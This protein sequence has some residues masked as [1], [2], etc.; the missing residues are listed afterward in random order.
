MQTHL[1]FQ[2]ALGHPKLE[3]KYLLMN[4][5]CFSHSLY[6]SHNTCIF[7][8][9]VTVS[10]HLVSFHP[11][12]IHFPGLYTVIRHSCKLFPACRQVCVRFVTDCLLTSSNTHSPTS[13]SDCPILEILCYS[14]GAFSYPQY[15][16]KQFHL[17]KYNKIQ[18]IKHNSWYLSPLH[19]WTPECQL[20]GV[21]AQ[22]ES[23][24]LRH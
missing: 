8:R 17:I 11:T 20:Q 23:L 9:P 4:T 15:I 7:L 22:K 6:T 18:I 14:Y 3:T 10:C 2:T 24:H 19:I 13:W 1:M 21:Y 16:D 5:L 12:L